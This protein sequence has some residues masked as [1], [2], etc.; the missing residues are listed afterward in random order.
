[1]KIKADYWDTN[2]LNGSL[3][4]YPEIP[5]WFGAQLKTI[6]LPESSEWGWPC[7]ITPTEAL[8][9]TGRSRCRLIE[10]VNAMPPTVHSMYVKQPCCVGTE[11]QTKADTPW[12]N[13]LN[14]GFDNFVGWS[15]MKHQS[16]KGREVLII[17]K[18]E[19]Y[20]LQ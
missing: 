1:M 17:L 8:S 9:T 18:N 14:L 7:I 2:G 20:I 16:S 6:P 12:V 11:A 15:V 19:Q 3:G 5:Q 4:G 10:A 13:C